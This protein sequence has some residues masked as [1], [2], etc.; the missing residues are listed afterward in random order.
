MKNKNFVTKAKILQDIEIAK[1]IGS[2][3]KCKT[4]KPLALYTHTHTHTSI[5][6]N[7]KIKIKKR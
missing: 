2:N 7:K 5:L 1:K 3:K 4:L 6:N